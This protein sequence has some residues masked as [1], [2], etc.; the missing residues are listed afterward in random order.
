M[1]NE[2]VWTEHQSTHNSIDQKRSAIEEFTNNAI[3]NDIETKSET[4]LSQRM[5]ECIQWRKSISNKEAIEFRETKTREIE[6][7]GARL[8]K[9]QKPQAW[10]ADAD[11]STKQIARDVNGPLME[12]LLGKIGYEDPTCAEISREGAPIAG[13]LPMLGTDSNKMRATMDLQVLR[14]QMPM[15][16]KETVRKSKEDKHAQKLLD[17]IE[18][19]A[20]EGRMTMPEVITEDHVANC[21]L[22]NRFSVEQGFKEDGSTKVRAVDDETASGVNLCTEGGDKINCESLDMLVDAVK[23]F[24]LHQG[25][26][27]KLG[28][29]KADIKSA[30][31]RL[32]IQPEHRWMAWVLVKK[33][34][35][36]Y[37]ARHNACMF[38][39][40]ASVVAWDRVGEMIKNICLS[41]LKIPSLRWVDDFFGVEPAGTT[42]HCKL[43]FARCVRAMLGEGAIEPQKLQHGKT[44]TILGIDVRLGKKTVKMWPTKQKVQQWTAEL[45]SHDATGEMTPGAASKMAGRLNFAVQHCFKKVGRAMVRPF[46]AKQYSKGTGMST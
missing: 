7:L 45:R 44:L 43:C 37:V 27:K 11:A 39:A 10:L 12:H 42:E 29:W 46:Y 23:Q 24:S 2:S 32:P 40:S 4:K 30:Y 13:K 18:A 20:A 31:R 34:G 16:N 3:A 21:L 14:E 36:L 8:W 17:E 22:A 6:E 19:D 41:I 33:D 15:R 26:F 5:F 25:G 35:K 1:E 38:G 9:S 28:L